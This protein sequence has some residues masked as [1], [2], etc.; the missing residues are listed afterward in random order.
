MFRFA[1][2][3]W[4]LEPL[5]D[6]SCEPDALSPDNDHV[7]VMSIINIIGV[8]LAIAAARYPNVKLLWY[9]CN[10]NHVHLALLVE[11]DDTEAISEFMRDVNSSIGRRMNWLQQGEGK[12]WGAEASL[13]PIVNDEVWEEKLV[14]AVTNPV[15]DGQIPTVSRSCFFSTWQARAQNKTLR[16]WDFDNDAYKAAKKRARGK[17]KKPRLKDFI[18]WHELELGAFP[19]WSHLKPE[20]Q[21]TRFKKLM[22]AEEQKI[23]SARKEESKTFV[24]EAKL[25]QLDP[26]SR[27]KNPR[28]RKKRPLCYG[29]TRQD[30]LDYKAKRQKVMA[31]HEQASLAY[32]QGMTDVVFPTG[33]FRPPVV[34]PLRA[35]EVLLIPP[36]PSL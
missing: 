6:Q 18:V 20:Q 15:K 35:S 10:I 36:T 4:S 11:D 13:D 32:R 14:Y 9:E 16:Y 8:A 3:H 31:E 2:S 22:E 30:L 23:Q 17:K 12:F 34:R 28:K 26:R 29:K 21:R 1:P 33:T 25:R 24:G 27:P 19:G 5:L 7:P